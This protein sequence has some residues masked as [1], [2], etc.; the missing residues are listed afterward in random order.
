MLSTSKVI[1]LIL[2]KTAELVLLGS[3]WALK[4]GFGTITIETL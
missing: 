4:K 2:L 3:F 1:K